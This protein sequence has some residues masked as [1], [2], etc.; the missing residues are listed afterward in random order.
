ML[1]N[2]VLSIFNDGCMQAIVHSC[3]TYII[4]HQQTNEYNVAN[5]T[6]TN[7]ISAVDIM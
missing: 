4:I 3:S 1:S 5:V 6:N 2:Y 7:V